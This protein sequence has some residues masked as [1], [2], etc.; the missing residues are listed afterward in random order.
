MAVQKVA[1]LLRKELLPFTP[2]KVKEVLQ[3]YNPEEAIKTGL[4]R[5]FGRLEGGAKSPLYE[6]SPR[7]LAFLRAFAKHEDPFRALADGE[8]RPYMV[9]E[10]FVDMF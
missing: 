5:E 7:I 6:A 4:N 9:A 2:E 10:L 8:F 1:E 3:K